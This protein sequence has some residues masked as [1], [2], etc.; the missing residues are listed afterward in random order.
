VSDISRLGAYLGDDSV[1]NY[2]LAVSEAIKQVL[3]LDSPRASELLLVRHAEADISALSRTPP[4]TPPLTEKGRGQAQLLAMKLAP[5][6]IDAL[7]TS[8]ADA[9]LETATIL[10]TA[11]RSTPIQVSDLDDIGFDVRLI[12][13]SL[14]RTL[15]I[16][17]IKR[18]LI[19]NPRWDSLPA[20]DQSRRFRHR[21]IQA[22]EAIVSSHPGQRVVIVTHSSVI[23]VY[24]SMVLGIERDMF[25]LPEH[26]SVSRIRIM[27]DL[28]AVQNLNDISHIPA[29]SP[30]LPTSYE[31]HRALT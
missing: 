20:F 26:T 11:R 18:R 4:Q 7:Y 16:H 28:Y 17:A 5:E 1:S 12:P 2:A 21:V 23:N 25:F 19:A 15:L 3:T 29:T 31:K 9:A 8:P 6:R 30:P 24:A 14:P 22:I 13:G 10:G 27:D